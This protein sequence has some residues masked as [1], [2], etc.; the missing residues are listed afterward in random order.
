MTIAQHKQDIKGRENLLAKVLQAKEDGTR[1]VG[2]LELC[3]R[4]LAVAAAANDDANTLEQLADIEKDIAKA[5]NEVERNKLAAEETET[6]L[7]PLRNSLAQSEFEGKRTEVIKKISSIMTAKRETRLDTLIGEI[8]QAVEELRSEYAGA[9][10]V[11]KQFLTEGNGDAGAAGVVRRQRE[12]AERSLRTLQLL[13]ER[14]VDLIIHKLEDGL[15]FP[16][17]LSRDA[18]IRSRSKDVHSETL[19]ALDTAIQDVRKLTPPACT[20]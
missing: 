8:M 1:R 15:Q 14:H 18:M 17:L 16:S 7:I 9:H 20:A 10:L 12:H 3:R 4:N 2:E 19:I 6:A 11:M 5:K 13:A